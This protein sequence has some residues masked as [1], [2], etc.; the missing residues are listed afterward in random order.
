MISIEFKVLRYA[1]MVVYMVASIHALFRRG[2]QEV[3]NLSSSKGRVYLRCLE[4]H[5]SS[6]LMIIE[7]IDF[8]SVV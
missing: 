3:G 5:H 2:I 7:L 6:H 4:S 8:H 1:L